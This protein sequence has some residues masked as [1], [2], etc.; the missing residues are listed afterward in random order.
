MSAHRSLL[1]LLVVLFDQTHSISATL[2]CKSCTHVADAA[3]IVD[4]ERSRERY[5]SYEYKPDTRSNPL[6]RAHR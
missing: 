1:N 5:A 2:L 3:N 6:C 4:M